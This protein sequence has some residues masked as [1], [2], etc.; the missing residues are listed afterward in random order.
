MM[1]L[2]MSVFT[3]RTGV[4]YGQGISVAPDKMI[5]GDPTP[6]ATEWVLGQPACAT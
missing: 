1:A 4:S 2:T 5:A 3:D 6:A